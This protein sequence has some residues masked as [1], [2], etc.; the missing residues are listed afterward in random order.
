MTK[1]KNITKLK[2]KYIDLYQLVTN[3]LSSHTGFLFK[4][5]GKW[6]FSY[7]SFFF[8]A[9][10]IL[11]TEKLKKGKRLDRSSLDRAKRKVFQRM[12]EAFEKDYKRDFLT[13]LEK[14]Y[15]NLFNYLCDEKNP[16]FKDGYNKVKREFYLEIKDNLISDMKGKE[17]QKTLIEEK[18]E[19]HRVFFGGEEKCQ[20]TLI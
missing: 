1:E 14:K 5:E 6:L 3:T 7:N 12:R 4:K 18:E 15:L 16:I 17:R 13:R 19:T 8:T 11:Q 10:S 2:E 20:N 9:K